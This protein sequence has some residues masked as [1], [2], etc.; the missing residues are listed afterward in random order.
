VMLGVGGVVALAARP[1]TG[2]VVLIVCVAGAA[3]TV[4]AGAW[5]GA[6]YTQL[7]ARREAAGCGGRCATCTLSCR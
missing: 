6:R 3:G 4:G 2:L 7:A 1:S 5:Q